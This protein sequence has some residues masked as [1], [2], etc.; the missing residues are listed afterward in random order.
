MK[1]KLLRIIIVALIIL[2]VSIT[3]TGCTDAGQDLLKGFVQEWINTKFGIDTTDTSFTGKIAAGIKLLA[4]FNEDSTGNPD[5]DAALGTVKMV[6]NF[7][8]AEEAMEKGR[9]NSDANSMDQAIALRP[10][11]WSYRA[12]RCTLALQQNQVEKGR[13]EWSKGEDL[14]YGDHNPTAMK[15]FYSQS[16]N[17]LETWKNSGQLDKANEDQQAFAYGTLVSNYMG[18]YKLTKDPKDKEMTLYY[19][20]QWNHVAGLEPGK[21]PELDFGD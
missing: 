9:K 7:K 13:K 5:S 20:A 19:N 11:D 2:T 14:A 8:D 3:A 21:P 4:L 15:R 16:I 17:E 18:R 6:K 10:V 12:S 1:N